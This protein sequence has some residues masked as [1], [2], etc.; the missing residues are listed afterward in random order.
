MTSTATSSGRPPLVRQREGRWLTGVAA[1]LAE[2]LNFPVAILRAGFVVLAFTGI[3]IVAYAF[4]W[5]MI[6]D[7]LSAQKHERG[8]D[9][10]L[11][12]SLWRDREDPRSSR[13]RNFLAIMLAVAGVVIVWSLIYGGD[14]STRTVLVPVMI[15][16]LGLVVAWGQLDMGPQARAGSNESAG[17]VR[18]IGGALLVLTGLVMMMSRGESFG[19]T[20]TTMIGALAALGGVAVVFA[21]WWLS[22]VR[23]LGD[24]RAARARE[25]ERADIAAHLHDSVLQTLALIRANP[26]DADQ[27]TRLAR[28]QERELREWLYQDR[29]DAS[30]SL[31]AA[32]R[33][34]VAVIEDERDVDI[35]FVAVGDTAMSA[36]TQALVQATREAVLNAVRHGAPPVTVFCEVASGQ[37]EVFVRDRG[38]GF[39]PAAIAPDR[40]GVRE[41]IIGRIERVGGTASLKVDNGTEVHLQ[42]PLE[43]EQ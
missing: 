35:A 22:M 11:W 42:V 6:P 10:R 32:L 15:A 24:E 18:V 43:E 7:E 34:V 16:A 3:G 20:M 25:T 23:A 28:A 5:V 17:M 38:P 19:S 37:T 13:M 4:W 39:D 40:F 31:A 36:V 1:G 30:G 26:T 9:A 14:F 33:E 21:P 41:S 12:A 27:V 2:H 8:Q 29:A